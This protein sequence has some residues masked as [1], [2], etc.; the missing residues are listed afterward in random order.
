LLLQLKACGVNKSKWFSPFCPW[1]RILHLCF[2]FHTQRFTI[3]ASWTMCS[4]D[5]FIEALIQ[6]KDKLIKMGV[7]KKSKEHA[8]VVHDGRSSQNIKSK[9][10]GKTKS[11]VESKKEGYSKPFNDSLRSK[12]GKGNKGHKCTYCNRGFH[13]KSVCMKKKIDLM[14]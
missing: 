3:G 6:E 4:L 8:L 13:P 11:C 12:S 2:Q 1:S 14:T 5:T 9:V 7:I 10:K